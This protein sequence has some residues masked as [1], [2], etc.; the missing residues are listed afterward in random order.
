MAD[1]R[2]DGVFN[3]RG[4]WEAMRCNLIDCL[5]VRDKHSIR[6]DTLH[7]LYCEKSTPFTET[8]IQ[9]RKDAEHG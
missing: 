9:D 6:G 1:E 3:L 2:K 7:C 5:W 8:I 4:G